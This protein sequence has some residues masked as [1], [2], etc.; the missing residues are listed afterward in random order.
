MCGK[1]IIIYRRIKPGHKI[2]GFPT[3]DIWFMSQIVKT[4]EWFLEDADK[5]IYSWIS[6]DLV[7][8]R[9]GMLRIIFLPLEW[10][11]EDFHSWILNDFQRVSIPGFR[12]F[13]AWDAQTVLSLS[14]HTITPF[15]YKWTGWQW[16]INLK[17]IIVDSKSF[18]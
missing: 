4:L 1:L 12:G 6:L 9:L 3:S 13:V 15:I 2:F 7:D 10:F 16:W 14:T 5:I 11:S 18:Y 17:R 8:L